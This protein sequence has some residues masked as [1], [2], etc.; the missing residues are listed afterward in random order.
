MI[1]SF[2]LF[3]RP[4][5][6]MAILKLPPV[7]YGINLPVETLPNTPYS[8]IQYHDPRVSQPISP[9][10]HPPQKSSNNCGANFSKSSTYIPHISLPLSPTNKINEKESKKHTSI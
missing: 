4:F 8:R 2:D 3:V 9:S 10:P 5:R 7:P 1:S 6:R